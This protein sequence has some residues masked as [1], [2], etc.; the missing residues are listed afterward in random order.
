M[1]I[2]LALVGS[3]LVAAGVIWRLKLSGF[4]A[5]KRAR[6]IFIPLSKVKRP[7]SAQRSPFELEEEIRWD[8]EDR[9]VARKIVEEQR[10]SERL[11]LKVPIHIVGPMRTEKRSSNG[12]RR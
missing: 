4:A 5:P 1:N 7:V 8:R 6:R 2:P 12:L 11:L 10:R 3:A 9:K